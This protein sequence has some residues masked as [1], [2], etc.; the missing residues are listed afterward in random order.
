MTPETSTAISSSKYK[1]LGIQIDRKNPEFLSD[2][3]KTLLVEGEYIK[4]SE[5]IPQ[6]LARPAVNFCYGDYELAQRIYDYAYEGFFMYASPVL[7]NATAGNWYPDETRDGAHYWHKSTFIPI[8]KPQGQPISCFAFE[9][10]DTV[11]GQEDT[12]KEL[13]RLSVSGGGTG[14]HNSIRATTKKA[15]GPI[16]YM[17]LLDSAIGYFKQSGTRKGALAYYM[18]V[19]HPDIKEHIR[20]RVPGGDSKRRSDNRNQFHT[21][22]NL[23][24][25]FINAVIEDTDFDLKCPH[26]K[27]VYETVK[28][29]ALWE[30][31]VETRALTGE[32][33]LMKTGLAN[34]RMP[35]TQK[36]LGLKIRGSNLCTE[37]TLPTDELRTFVCCLSSLNLAKYAK[38][39]DTRI[40]EDLIRFLDNVLQWFIDTAPSSL[41]KAKFSAERE[42]ALGLGSFGWHS[43]LQSEMIPFESGGFN[44]A[45]QYAVTIHRLIKERA[46]SESLRLGAERGEAP[47]M[48]GTGMRNSR[49][50]AIAPNANS[51]DIAN[52]S[53]SVEPWYRN[54]F[55]K[56][57]R[58]GMFTVKNPYLEKLLESLGKNTKAVWK[59]IDDHDGSVQHLDFL[60]PHQKKVFRCAMELDQHW[61]IEHANSR[62]P[63]I[64][65]AQSLN[66]F[67]PPGSYRQYVNSVHLKFLKASDVITLYYYRTERET[68]VD[69]VKEIQRQALIDWSGE[70][71]VACGG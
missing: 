40:V 19:D 62:G 37:I 49:L 12:I 11:E 26:S 2:F 55:L 41:K 21:A 32:P 28:A 45:S 52:T 64:C 10:P 35:E 69:N 71:C 7:S 1:Y 46:T 24:D 14:A 66:L 61:L 51:A 27:K 43:F 57:T 67:F 38:W 13:A 53:P 6:A 29:R 20:F 22:V 58:A 8:K 23:T 30:D 65:Q 50:I 15:P 47:D 5:T 16:P 44:S 54:V 18:D 34:L 59:D 68:K 39:K 4:G 9:I 56:D 3:S 33:F 70:E 17:K 48:I 36:L 25:E 60:D 31:I 63:F 42:R